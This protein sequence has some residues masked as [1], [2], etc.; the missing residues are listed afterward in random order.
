MAAPVTWTDPATGLPV[1][2]G[3]VAAVVEFQR[4]LRVD[5]SSGPELVFVVSSAGNNVD[6]AAYGLRFDSSAYSFA[7]RS[8]RVVPVGWGELKSS[9][10]ESYKRTV[11]LLV[12][13]ARFDVSVRQRLCS[14]T[15]QSADKTMVTAAAALRRRRRLIGV[16]FPFCF[17][18]A[19]HRCTQRARGATATRPESPQTQL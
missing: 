5:I 14:P 13:K 15:L 11:T 18:A 2:T 4:L 19:A 17:P 16:T 12:G 3:A 6:P 1:T 9:G 8:G 7:A 10:I